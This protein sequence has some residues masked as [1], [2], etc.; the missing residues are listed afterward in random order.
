M[1]IKQKIPNYLTGFR[2]AIIPMVAVVF[3]MDGLWT[4][5][6]AWALFT[7]AGVTDYFDGMMARKWNVQSNLGR[8]MDPIADKLLVAVCIMLLVHGN[9]VDLLPAI[10]VI[11]REI[12]ISGLREFLADKEINVPVTFLA[13]IKTT[14]Q[15][16]AI[17]GLLLAP[18][19]PDWWHFQFLSNLL[20]WVAAI[21][22]IIT[23]W[24]YFRASWNHF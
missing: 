17:G 13:K 24:Q 11:F 5:W 16:F 6:A 8:F 14:V 12:F 3:F 18:G 20:F 19:T 15:M 22:T 10:L 7:I 21:L 1:S 2:I 9:R 4:Y 23:G